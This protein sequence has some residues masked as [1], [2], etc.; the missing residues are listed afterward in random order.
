MDF[1]EIIQLDDDRHH[2][3]SYDIK[4]SP[5]HVKVSVYFIYT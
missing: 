2:S 5:C 1:T 3:E 4:L